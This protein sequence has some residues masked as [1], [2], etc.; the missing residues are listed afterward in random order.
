[1]KHIAFTKAEGAQNDFVI[2]DDRTRVLTDD[3]RR[4]FAQLTAH[5]RKGV[6]SDG[7]IIIDA[8]ETHDFTMHFFNPDGSV[9][10][11]CG[12]GGRCAALFAW[13]KQI[14]AANMCFEVLGRSYTASVQG[15]EITLSFPPPRSIEGWKDLDL[16]TDTLRIFVIDTGAP[17]V[18][19]LHEQLPESFAVD[20]EELDMRR[21][22]R[23]V[24]HHQ[25]FAPVG[26]NVNVL[27]KHGLALDI[28]TFE[29][30]V[31]DETEACGTGT[32][33]AAIA[34]HIHYGIAPPL[35]LH[36]H[37]GDTLHVG[38]SP[39]SEHNFLDTRYYE[40]ALF[41]HG[42]ARLVFDGEYVLE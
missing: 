33:A 17:H 34:A 32:I 20:F 36:T 8:S 2:V 10:S 31:E 6:G 5:R 38:F 23:I 26:V 9:G 15:D 40:N 14:A 19:L 41:L 27:R 22:G 42:P 11:M 7:T 30:G 39:A 37:G 21:I 28:R 16:N 12:N 1:M 18:V 25:Y 4:R 29:K 24:R 35:E 3:D 13:K